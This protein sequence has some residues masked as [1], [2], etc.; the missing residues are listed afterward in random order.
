MHINEKSWRRVP[1]H[2]GHSF[3]RR[4]RNDF[5]VDLGFKRSNPKDSHYLMSVHFMNTCGVPCCYTVLS[6]AHNSGVMTCH[7]SKSSSYSCFLLAAVA[8]A[9]IIYLSIFVWN[10][11]CSEFVMICCLYHA[12]EFSIWG[13]CCCC[14]D[15]RRIYMLNKMSNGLLPVFAY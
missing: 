9:L 1:G 4:R 12:T 6:R 10:L 2:G 14:Y 8:G 15:L 11:N 3:S 5:L 13:A 7:Y